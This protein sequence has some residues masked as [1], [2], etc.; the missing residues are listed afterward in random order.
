MISDG[1]SILDI[2]C[3]YGDIPYVYAD[4]R[5]YVDIELNESYIQGARR[6]NA[7]NDA[8]YIVGDIADSEVRR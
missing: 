2:G 7:H 5:K 6:R 1:L 3:G 4:R 8:E